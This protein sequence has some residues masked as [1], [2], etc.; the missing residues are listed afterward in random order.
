M[1]VV[2]AVLFETRDTKSLTIEL[3]GVKFRKQKLFDQNN[4]YLSIIIIAH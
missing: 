2:A 3:Q 4:A 1:W